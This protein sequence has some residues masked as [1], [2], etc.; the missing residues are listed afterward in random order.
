MQLAIEPIRMAPY[1][2]MII[3]AT[4]PHA[5]PPAKVAFCTCI[6][7]NLPLGPTQIE[8]TNVTMQLD[9]NAR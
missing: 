3:S 1:G 4:A 7:F 9:A 8:I 5:T 6:M 2:C